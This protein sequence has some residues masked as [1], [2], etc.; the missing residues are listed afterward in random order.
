MT[1][2]EEKRIH[3][4]EKR[5]KRRRRE[6]MKR[7]VCLVGVI[8]LAAAVIGGISYSVSKAK[9]NQAREAAAKAKQEA[10]LKKEKEEKEAEIKKQKEEEKRAADNTLTPGVPVGSDTASTEKTVYLTFD[11]GPSQNTQPILD[12]LDQYNAKATFFVTGINQDYGDLIKT[13]Y[14]KGHTIGLH[15]FSHSYQQLYASTDA[16]FDDLNQIGE[17]VKQKIGFVPC[18]IRFPGGSS[19][20]VSASYSQGIMTTLSQAVQEKGYQYYDWN[21][22]SGDAT[23]SNVPKDTIVAEGTSCE[24]T[25]I[26]MLLHDAIGKETTVEAL[27]AIIE[28]YQSLGYTF[29]A[30]D[31]QSFDAHHGIWN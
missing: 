9:K 27:P 14:D 11:D 18:F 23:G 28:H 22:S 29:K 13:A 26:V 30:L 19:N 17:Y 5:Q 16:Y 8:L 7:L 10:V 20:T 1:E 3:R 25:N 24:Y 15:T 21:A 4:Y 31:R 2:E 6:L 12:I